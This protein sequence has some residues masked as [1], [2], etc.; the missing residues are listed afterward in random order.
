MNLLYVLAM[1][2]I[3]RATDGNPISS[4]FTYGE[5]GGSSCTQEA[6]EWFRHANLGMFMHNGP[7]TQWGTEI[8]FPLVCQAF[9]CTVKGPNNTDI[10]IAT[11]SELKSH[12]EA[13]AALS[14]TWNPLNFNATDIAERA[15]AAGFKYLVYTTVHCGTSNELHA[16]ALAPRLACHVTRNNHDQFVNRRVRKL[17]VQ[18]HVVQRDEHTV[19]S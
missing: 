8:S 19:R 5:E 15:E 3:L 2:T 6:L 13:Y 4:P 14:K 10:D 9:P 7:I 11:P 1:A 16:F 12:R 17:A 18:R